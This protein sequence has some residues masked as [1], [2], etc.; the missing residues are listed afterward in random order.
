M[1]QSSQ[2]DEASM[3]AAVAEGHALVPVLLLLLGTPLLGV[4]AVI[5]FIV[6]AYGLGQELL[7]PLGLIARDGTYNDGPSGT[8]WAVVASLLIASGWWYSARLVL[9]RTGR[10]LLVWCVA[11]VMGVLPLLVFVRSTT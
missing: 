10:P 9:R 3:D 1:A 2:H 4:L 7:A 6:S 11:V 8:I 5:P